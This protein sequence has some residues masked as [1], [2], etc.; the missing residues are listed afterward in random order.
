MHANS[1]E[2]KISDC[3]HKMP[4]NIPWCKKGSHYLLLE[5]PVDESKFLRV[6][7]FFYTKNVNT[8]PLYFPAQE[9]ANYCSFP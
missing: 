5:N 3:V 6:R 2:S 7:I 9:R 8:P 1:L 4:R